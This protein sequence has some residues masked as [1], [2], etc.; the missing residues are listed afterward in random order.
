MIEVNEVTKKY[1]DTLEALKTFG[2]AKRDE[3]RKQ[4]MLDALKLEL[5]GKRDEAKAIYQELAKQQKEDGGVSDW[6][7]AAEYRLSWWTD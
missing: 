4:K 6:P 5:E 3:A 1:G 7:F 2:P